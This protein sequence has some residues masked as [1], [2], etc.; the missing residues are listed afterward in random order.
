MGKIQRSFEI[1]MSEIHGVHLSIVNIPKYELQQYFDTFREDYNT[2]TLPHIKYYNYD[3]W[4]LEE[5]SRLRQESL[6][7]SSSFKAWEDERVHANKLQFLA[8]QKEQAAM[9]LVAASMNSSKIADMQHQKQLQAQ[10]QVAFKMGDSETYRKLK[11]KLQ[12][13]D[14]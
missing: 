12:P 3:K 7:D 8:K 4:E 13:P 1:W 14:K 6:K 2:A 9:E 10:M 11:E 5:H